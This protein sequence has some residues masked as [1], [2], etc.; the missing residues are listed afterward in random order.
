[1]GRITAMRPS[2]S[3]RAAHSSTPARPLLSHSRYTLSGGACTVGHHSACLGFL[4]IAAPRPHGAVAVPGSSSSPDWAGAHWPPRTSHGTGSLARVAQ[5]CRSSWAPVSAPPPS[6][7]RGRGLESARGGADNSGR[8]RVFGMVKLWPPR[9]LRPIGSMRYQSDSTT[10][11]VPIN[12]LSSGCAGSAAPL[13]TEWRTWRACRWAILARHPRPPWNPASRDPLAASFK[14]RIYVS[15][16]PP[17][18]HPFFPQ[19]IP[20]HGSRERERK[21]RRQVDPIAAASNRRRWS[22][23]TSSDRRK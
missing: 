16:C 21:Q 4:P 1:M 8:V 15:S 9:T 12:R 20:P 11:A 19:P 23:R 2:Y 14:S 17:F 7:S 22:S 3:N 5:R 13:S 18:S 6:S 10:N